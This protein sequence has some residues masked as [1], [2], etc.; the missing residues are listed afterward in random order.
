[1]LMKR[2]FWITIAII[3]I[4]AIGIAGMSGKFTKA[5]V[6]APAAARRR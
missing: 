4:A 6:G 1:M 5:R 2:S 3:A